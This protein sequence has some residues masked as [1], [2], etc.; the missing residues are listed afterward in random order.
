MDMPPDRKA[1]LMHA[2]L[3]R[4]GL[5]TL[6]TATLEGEETGSL[7]DRAKAIFDTAEE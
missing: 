2:I 1:E 6:L 4:K 7:A 3:Y 5:R